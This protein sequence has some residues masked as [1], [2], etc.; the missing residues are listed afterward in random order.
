[1]PVLYKEKSIGWIH[2]DIHQVLLKNNFLMDEDKV[3]VDNLLGL[4]ENWFKSVFKLFFKLK[5]IDNN[6]SEKCPI[7]SYESLN[8]K[9]TF[10]ENKVFGNECLFTVNRALLSKFGFTAYGVHC[11][12]WRNNK[13]PTMFLSK[14][15]RNLKKF[16]G[17]FDNFIGGGQPSNISIR[18]NLEKEG[19]EEVGI[20]KNILQNAELNC[21]TKYSHTYNN[22]LNSS[23]IATYDLEMKKKFIFKSNDNEVEGV[24]EFEIFEV[25]NL[26]KEKKIKPNCLIP[27]LNLI[28][29]KMNNL[30][31]ERALLE[32]KK[33]LI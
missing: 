14:R 24:Q 21:F 25:L 22:V 19:F 5:I 8:P 7:F 15:S 28:I 11:N 4:E 17:L 16:P 27:I 31:D 12:A 1:M 26:F 32:I 2:A 9:I 20:T 29:K 33:N 6:F 23:V 18:K 3:C 10:Q 13:V 30:F